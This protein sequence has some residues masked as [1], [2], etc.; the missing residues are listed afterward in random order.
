MD[1]ARKVVILARD[2]GLDIELGSLALESLVPGPLA[3]C[4]SVEEYLARLPEVRGARALGAPVYLVLAR[5]AV[6]WLCMGYECGL[7]P[8]TGRWPGMAN[9]NVHELD[10]GSPV[11]QGLGAAS[12]PGAYLHLVL[13][14]LAVFPPTLAV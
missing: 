11:L 13:A 7:M 2:C 1:V 6:K 14:R 8:V 9:G 10:I 5:L 4:T 3:A 12:P